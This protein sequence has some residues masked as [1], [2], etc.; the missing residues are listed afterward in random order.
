M[1]LPDDQK[2]RPG[3][4]G[5]EIPGNRAPAARE[6][7]SRGSET[8]EKQEQMAADVDTMRKKLQAASYGTG[9]RGVGVSYEGLFKNLDRDN[10]VRGPTQTIFLTFSFGRPRLA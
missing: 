7:V 3:D 1:Y 8:R 9:R 4:L 5:L 2:P 6:P 10:S